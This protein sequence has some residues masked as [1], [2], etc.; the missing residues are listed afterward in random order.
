VVRGQVGDDGGAAVGGAGVRILSSGTIRVAATDGV[1]AFR[2]DA[3]A[4][5]SAFLAITAEGFAAHRHGQVMPPALELNFTLARGVRAKA[6]F[7][8]EG[9]PATGVQATMLENGRSQVAEADADGMTWF[10]RVAAPEGKAWRTISAAGGG[11][12]ALTKQYQDLQPTDGVLDF[13][14]IELVRGAVV[15]GRVTEQGTGAPI[16][17]AMVRWWGRTTRGSMNAP[18][19]GATSD[20][21]GRYE[22]TGVPL[23]VIEVFANKDGFDNGIDYRK[24]WERTQS[25]KEGLLPAGQREL[26]RD[27]ELA[28]FGTV[29]GQVLHATGDP[30]AG[31]VVTGQPRGF[32][33]DRGSKPAETTTGEDGR[34][35][36]RDY[37]SAR[38]ARQLTASHPT[39]GVS[40]PVVVRSGDTV[41]VTLTLRATVRMTGRVVD[42]SG[43]PVAD[44]G[45]S[46]S[47]A[48]PGLGR[49]APTATS[50]EEGRFMLRGVPTSDRKLRVSH[51][52]FKSTVQDFAVDGSVEEIAVGD[53]VLRRGAGIEGR[54]VDEKGMGLGATPVYLQYDLKEGEEATAPDPNEKNFANA[55]TRA[56]GSFGAF[57]LREGSYRVRVQIHD[58]FVESPT[59]RT[60]TTDLVLVARKGFV[61]QATIL[62]DGK[63]LQQARV[64]A[65]M[66]GTDSARST[67]IES[68]GSD[69]QGRVRLTKLPPNGTFNLRVTHG[70]YQTYLRKNVRAGDLPTEI[71]MVSGFALEGVVTDT[72]GKP[73][74]GVGVQASTKTGQGN[75][76]RGARTDEEGRFRISGLEQI[77]YSLRVTVVPGNQIRPE[78][79]KVTPGGDAIR[80][81]LTTGL[82]IEGA[83]KTS[84]EATFPFIRIEAR[85]ADD[86]VRQTGFVVPR[87]Q[88]RFELRG[89]PPGNY[90]VRFVTG[91]GD[92]EKER[93][94]LTDVAAGTKDLEVEIRGQ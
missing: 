51:P 79:R 52:R 4:N 44:A 34:F 89:L 49:V 90:T 75:A 58:R 36:L 81:E 7:V 37:A 45:I 27:I 9:E 21:E 74:A 5:R 35:E 16:E 61:W 93:A 91:W 28:R 11:F 84:K 23:D 22:L 12:V 32:P 10:D 85:D 78:P 57:G 8:C 72:D 48:R 86:K 31:A 26:T 14:E 94:R 30:V 15:R 59:V 70:D 3:S 17:G 29:R 66:A 65:R 71:R 40:D 13:G 77:E 60:G 47:P 62:G 88:L 46:A 73:I 55:V 69:E 50:N 18:L 80:L 38:Q 33:M 68:A 43:R 76:W 67:W 83:V 41:D 54:L 42:E 39:L 82:S 56:D 2:L 63:P 53:L 19:L 24:L 92:T 1:G 6:R 64:M 20:A 87:T 25:S